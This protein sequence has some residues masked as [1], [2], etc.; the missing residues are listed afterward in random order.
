[1]C[2]GGGAGV[3]RPVIQSSSHPIITLRQNQHKCLRKATTITIAVFM[4][5]M[6]HIQCIKCRILSAGEV[7]LLTTVSPDPVRTRVQA[8]CRQGAK[9]GCSVELHCAV[10]SHQPV[11]L[12]AGLLHST[13]VHGS[14]YRTTA[15]EYTK[16]HV[17][18]FKILTLYSKIP[19]T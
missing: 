15:T 18:L 3:R 8:G 16:T 19:L 9:S 6:M 2:G 11:W 4:I 1:M 13:R 5:T 7:A 14:N 10:F 12:A 17:R